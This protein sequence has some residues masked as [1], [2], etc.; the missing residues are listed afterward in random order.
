MKLYQILG[1][2]INIMAAIYFLYLAA[3]HIFVY[4]MN[5]RDGHYVNFHESAVNLG[6]GGIISLLTILAWFVIKN[7][8]T[9]KLGNF[10]LFTPLGLVIAYGLF[11]IFLLLASGGKWN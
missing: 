5:K 8:G 11:A 10:L 1:F 9:Q 4:V 6:V 2:S 3:M 7:S